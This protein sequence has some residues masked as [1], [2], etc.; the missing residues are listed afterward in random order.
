MYVFVIL[1]DHNIRVCKLNVHLDLETS[2]L[3][4]FELSEDFEYAYN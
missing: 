1:I 4:S 2:F 3:V